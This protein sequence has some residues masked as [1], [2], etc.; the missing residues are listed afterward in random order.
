MDTPTDLFEQYD[1]FQDFKEH[2]EKL[3]IEHKLK[4]FAWNVS[5]TAEVLD[6]QRSHF[7]IR[8]RNTICADKTSASS[9]QKPGILPGVCLYTGCCVFYLQAA[10]AKHFHCTL[11]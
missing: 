4:K 2:I 7:T 6:I 3:F 10:M 8:L 5:K 11:T 9:L 1:K